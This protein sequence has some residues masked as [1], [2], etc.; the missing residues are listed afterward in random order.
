[1][2]KKLVGIAVLFL[3]MVGILVGCGNNDQEET[4]SPQNDGDK[5]AATT[6]ESWKSVQGNG[7]L[8]VGLAELTLHLN[9]EMKKR[10]KSKALMSIWLMR[11]V[12]N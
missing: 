11:L 2:S 5:E 12:R 7:E 3:A 1:M 8:V 6:D 4:A 9:Q 10:V